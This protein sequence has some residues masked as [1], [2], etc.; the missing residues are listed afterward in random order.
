MPMPVVINKK[1][2]WSNHGKNP[3]C[4]RC[5][6]ESITTVLKERP[7]WTAC[8]DIEELYFFANLSIVPLILRHFDQVPQNVCPGTHMRQGIC[9]SW[10]RGILVTARMWTLLSVIIFNTHTHISDTPKPPLTTHTHK[11]LRKAATDVWHSE[12]R[13]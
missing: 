6:Q 9:D 10:G 12:A 3:L 4:H 1:D 13:I 8:V 7:K 11:F 2:I 5:G